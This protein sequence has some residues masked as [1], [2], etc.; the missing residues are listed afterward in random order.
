LF[1][2][3]A[4]PRLIEAFDREIEAFLKAATLFEPPVDPVEIPYE[5]ITLPG[6]LP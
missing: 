6:R 4:N 3:P 1:G 2:T 5:G